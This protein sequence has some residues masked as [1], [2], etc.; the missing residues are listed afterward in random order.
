LVA[1]QAR[2]TLLGICLPTL[3]HSCLDGLA[4]ALP[5]EPPPDHPPRCGLPPLSASNEPPPADLLPP[6][7]QEHIGVGDQR[8]LD[9]GAHEGSTFHEVRLFCEAI[10]GSEA[11]LRE[12]VTVED[13]RWAV[14]MGVAAQESIAQGGLPVSLAP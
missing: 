13:G 10:R 3:E 7:R 12:M 5:R 8:L 9:A 1:L 2:G 6:I 11:A 14:A 4:P